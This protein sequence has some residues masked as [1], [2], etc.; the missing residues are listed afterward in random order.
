MEDKNLILATYLDP[1]FK[2]GFIENKYSGLCNDKV[3]AECFIQDIY[4]IT[5]GKT[6]TS[7]K[8]SQ[9][10]ENDLSDMSEEK[11]NDNSDFHFSFMKCLTELKK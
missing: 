7:H 9:G 3:I 5:K 4:S 8:V 10:M 6:D 1:R 11:S 2:T